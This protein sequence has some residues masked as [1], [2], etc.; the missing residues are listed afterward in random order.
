[1]S[2]PWYLNYINYGSDWTKYYKVDPMS[3]GG[4]DEEINLVIG[5]EVKIDTF[6]I[7][8]ASDGKFTCS[9]G[10]KFFSH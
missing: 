4:D 3:F 6:K 7:E 10:T 9:R 2:A 1:M 8:I 5:G